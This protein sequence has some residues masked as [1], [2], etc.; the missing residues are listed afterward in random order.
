MH[1]HGT[2]YVKLLQSTDTMQ[3]MRYAFICSMHSV[4]KTSILFTSF[5][6]AQ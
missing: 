2:S 1:K 3:R 4:K 5:L 6:A